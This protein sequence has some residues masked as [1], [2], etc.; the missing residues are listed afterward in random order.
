MELRGRIVPLITI[1]NNYFRAGFARA[2][3]PN[4]FRDWLRSSQVELS[5]GSVAGDQGGPNNFR[6]LNRCDPK[7]QKYAQEFPSPVWTVLRSDDGHYKISHFQS[8][9]H[10]YTSLGRARQFK[11]SLTKHKSSPNGSFVTLTTDSDSDLDD[12][13]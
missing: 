9:N 4:P 1:T 6:L 11:Q 8:P 13:R 3:N 12:R 2:H 10:L 5:S 7:F